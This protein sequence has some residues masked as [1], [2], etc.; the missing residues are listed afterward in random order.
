MQNQIFVGIREYLLDLTKTLPGHF[1]YTN[2]KLEEFEEIISSSFYEKTVVIFY[3]ADFAI[4][5][6]KISQHCPQNVILLFEEGDFHSPPSFEKLTQNSLTRLVSNFLKIENVPSVT[7]NI[8][9]NLFFYKI[10]GYVPEIPINYELID[11]IKFFRSKL[12]G[13]QKQNFPESKKTFLKSLIYRL[14]FSFRTTGDRGLPVF[15]L[16]F[17]RLL[18]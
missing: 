11:T 9:N 4:N 15:Y 6:A 14:E 17:C 16:T 2:L 3:D 7:N 8:F 10:L 1:F 18:S 5:R 12:F 13:L